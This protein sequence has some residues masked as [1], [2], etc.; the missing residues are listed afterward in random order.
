MKI[1]TT[2]WLAPA[3]LLGMA[4]AAIAQ[5]SPWQ[6]EGRLGA[7]LPL[8]DLGD[9]ELDPGISL[10]ATLSY[11]LTD[12]LAVYGGWG[13]HLLGAEEVEATPDG[14]VEETGYVLGLAF[15]SPLAETGLDYR[16]HGGVTYEHIEIEDDDG[17]VVEDTGHGAGFEL[18]AALVWPLS[19]QLSLTPGLRYRYLSRD[20]EL[21]EQSSSEELTFVSTEVGLAWRF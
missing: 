1:L 2:R 16:L 15:E 17:D 7:A 3:L 4:P 5:E 9:V 13:W 14:A 6:I 11:R 19:E 10:S 21:G 20:I 18:G 8:G 12:S